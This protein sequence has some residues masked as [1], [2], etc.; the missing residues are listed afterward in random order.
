MPLS[1][2]DLDKWVTTEHTENK[3]IL[4]VK[5]MDAWMK[6]LGSRFNRVCYWDCFAGRGELVD[7]TYE[8]S[9]I[10]SPLLILELAKKYSQ[11]RKIL[12]IL[13][14]R[15]RNNFQN[16]VKLITKEFGQATE[17]KSDLC[18]WIRGNIAIRAMHATFESAGKEML[19]TIGEDETLVPS[20]FFID[21]FGFGGYPFEL[22][23][24]I[25]S[26]KRT[27]IF[28]TFMVRDMIRFID[29]A[30]HKKALDEIFGN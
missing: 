28:V 1:D 18:Q 24:K 20:F 5:Y 14:E 17:S 26:F 8:R 15:D 27:E 23:K 11:N 30:H 21:P 7:A 4:L 13:I 3:H 22:N 12:S 10:G 16:L 9:T 29:S 19:G 6:I 2:S 25:L